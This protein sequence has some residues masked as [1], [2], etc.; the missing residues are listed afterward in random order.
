MMERA[1]YRGVALLDGPMGACSDPWALYPRSLPVCK[2]PPVGTAEEAGREVSGRQGTGS[3]ARAV[4]CL[5]E[6]RL[7]DP[8]RAF[9]RSCARARAVR[10]CGA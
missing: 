1:P 2:R 4:C 3:V 6:A 9:V 7:T 5:A 10:G 8:R